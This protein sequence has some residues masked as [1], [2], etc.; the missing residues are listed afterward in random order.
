MKSFKFN[1]YEVSKINF[2]LK[3]N[4]L[5]FNANNLIQ[6]TQTSIYYREKAKFEFSKSID[7]LFQVIISFLNKHGIKRNDIEFL[8]LHVLV[9]ALTNLD[10]KELRLLIKDNI[11]HNKKE[12]IIKNKILLPDFISSYKDCYYHSIKSMRG[13]YITNKIQIGSIYYIKNDL[14]KLDLQNKIVLIENADTGYD[15]IFNY[16]IKGLITMYGGPNSHMSIRCNELNIPAVIGIGNK[17][18]NKLKKYFQIELN[19]IEKNIK[20]IK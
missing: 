1:K 7:L 10:Y 14:K 20:I 3:K 12:F 5:R 8:D 9:N 17:E 19:C 2:W 4:K 18:F 15:F 6:F 11:N 13:N 16:N